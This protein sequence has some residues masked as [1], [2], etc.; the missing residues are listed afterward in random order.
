MAYWVVG[1]P[2]LVV[3]GVLMVSCVPGCFQV[4]L[5][6][7]DGVAV[8]RGAAFDSIGDWVGFSVAFSY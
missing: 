7:L 6:L 8:P 2:F 5:V 4:L 1:A 3:L